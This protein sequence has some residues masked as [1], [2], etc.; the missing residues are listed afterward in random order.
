M[1]RSRDNIRHIR[2][3]RPVV[4]S[5]R[6]RWREPTEET[7]IADIITQIATSESIDAVEK[8]LESALEYLRLTRLKRERSER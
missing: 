8:T 2:P 6:D 5:Y 3:L 7:V 4:L 1:T